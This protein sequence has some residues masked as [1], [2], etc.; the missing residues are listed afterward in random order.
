MQVLNIKLCSEALNACIHKISKLCHLFIGLVHMRVH[1]RSQN[2]KGGSC[3][4]V[5]Q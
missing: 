3:I 4:E 5:F 2:S 1:G